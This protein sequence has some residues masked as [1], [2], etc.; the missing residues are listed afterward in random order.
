MNFIVSSRL[1]RKSRVANASQ[2]P[3]Q[4]PSSSFSFRRWANARRDYHY[5][6]IYSQHKEWVCCWIHD[7]IPNWRQILHNQP[8][9]GEMGELTAAKLRLQTTCDSIKRN[10]TNVWVLFDRKST[11]FIRPDQLEHDGTSKEKQ[12]PSPSLL[13]KKHQR[14][15]STVTR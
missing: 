15:K 7:R 3:W 14:P 13:P 10:M 5:L 8:T 11:D 1:G 2:S 9:P 12:K 6:V 4:K